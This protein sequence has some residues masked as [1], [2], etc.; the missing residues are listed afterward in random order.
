M[1]AKRRFAAGALAA[2]LCLTLRV[3][4]DPVSVTNPSFEQAP[5]DKTS[6]PG[7]IGGWVDPGQNWLP[8]AEDGK[9]YL[10][11]AYDGSNYNNPTATQETT[12]ILKE[13]DSITVTVAI[14]NDNYGPQPEDLRLHRHGIDYG[15]RNRRR[16]LQGIR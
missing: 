16:E 12:Y 15:P 1:R 3:G 5:G 11:L 8:T 13:G 7:W 6:A 9:T 2:G 10:R 4:A 14:G